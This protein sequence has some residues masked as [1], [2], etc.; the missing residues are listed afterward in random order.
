MGHIS[1]G[2]AIP[3]SLLSLVER[4]LEENN[5]LLASLKEGGA[6][7]EHEFFCRY[8]AGLFDILDPRANSS[9][10]TLWKLYNSIEELAV[11]TEERFKTIICLLDAI[12]TFKRY[13]VTDFSTVLENEQRMNQLR[14][15]YT[16]IDVPDDI[17]K[18]LERE[19]PKLAAAREHKITM[20]DFCEIVKFSV[21]VFYLDHKFAGI[22]MSGVFG[23]GVSIGEK[24]H[25]CLFDS[26]GNPVSEE[27][28]EESYE[29]MYAILFAL[30]RYR[31]AKVI[32]SLSGMRIYK[33]DIYETTQEE[34]NE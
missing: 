5:K 21:V 12:R 28:I 24:W 32:Y 2:V 6:T 25:A 10:Y 26:E 15:S 30:H 18:C 20:E 7:R 27:F 13:S 9:D 19:L 1:K 3:P 8:I 31:Q 14:I 23:G 4:E 29:Q 11:S 16:V 33:E 34:K 17:I 22:N